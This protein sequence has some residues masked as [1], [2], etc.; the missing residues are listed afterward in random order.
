MLYF[1]ELNLVVAGT[2]DGL[3]TMMEGE[4]KCLDHNVFLGIFLFSFQNFQYLTFSD[5]PE[6]SRLPCSRKICG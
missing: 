2:R 6:I 1:S 3:A 5:D 4:A